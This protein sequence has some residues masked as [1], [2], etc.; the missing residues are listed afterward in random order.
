VVLAVNDAEKPCRVPT[1]PKA[2]AVLAS[3]RTSPLGRLRV[4]LT[5]VRAT[6]VSLSQADW[7]NKEAGRPRLPWGDEGRTAFRPGVPVPI[8]N[9]CREAGNG[10]REPN[11]DQGL[12]SR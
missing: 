1:V 6:P 7:L 2:S 5:A 12:A 11:A 4:S 3:S 9:R 10:N 8:P